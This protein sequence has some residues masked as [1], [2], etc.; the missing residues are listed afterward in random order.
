MEYLFQGQ[1]DGG[2]STQRCPQ[3]S[4][5][6]QAVQDLLSFKHES[7]IKMDKMNEE[8]QKSAGDLTAQEKLTQVVIKCNQDLKNKLDRL[9]MGVFTGTILLCICAVG[10]IGNFVVKIH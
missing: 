5:I 4:G 2:D 7:Q 6:A 3:H 8:I 9:V 10:I 1:G